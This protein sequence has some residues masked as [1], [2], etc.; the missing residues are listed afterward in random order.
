MELQYGVNYVVNFCGWNTVIF[1]PDPTPL[2]TNADDE[3]MVNDVSSFN[4]NSKDHEKLL[5]ALSQ[6]IIRR[7]VRR[8]CDLVYCQKLL[9]RSNEYKAIG[10]PNPKSKLSI[11]CTL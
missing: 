11:Y 4:S 6:K 10:Q 7:G 1:T 3:I 2:D 9:D 5:P 8:I